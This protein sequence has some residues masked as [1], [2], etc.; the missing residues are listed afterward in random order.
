[1]TWGQQN[2]ESEAH[3]QLDY[4]L[5][6]GVNFIDTAEAY[7]VPVCKE[8]SGF[9]EQYIGSWIKNRGHRDDFILA[10]KIIGPAPYDWIRPSLDFNRDSILAAIEGSLRRLQTDYLDLYQLH[11]PER[12]SNFFGTLGYEHDATDS[13]TENFEEILATMQELIVAGK[14]RH[15][16]VSNETAW[17]TMKYLDVS[18]AKNLPRI[19]SVQNPYNL[20][21][22]SYEVGLAE[23]SMRESVGGLAYS[24]MAFG[25]LS[26]KYHEKKDQPENRLNQFEKLSR[27]ASDECWQA[28][29]EYLNIAEKYGVSLSQMS[30]AFVSSR[31]FITA[32]IIGAT[33]MTQLKENIES[34]KL[35]LTDEMLKDIN[36]VHRRISN[37]AP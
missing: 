28:T 24:P 6:N 36:E 17:G 31:P 21:N 3:E 34:S 15:V 9:T 2:T 16:G 4:A 19:Q 1:M 29:Q 7:A 23:V 25:L 35:V 13:W 18:S 27:Y 32:N 14:I 26:G 12:K 30:L 11:W 10:S 8:T 5:D 37:P 22:R 33:S 20:L